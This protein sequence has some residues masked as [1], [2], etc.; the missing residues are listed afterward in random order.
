[1]GGHGQLEIHTSNRQEVLLRHLAARLRDD[2]LLP[3]QN[4]TILVPGRAMARWL[5]L[6]LARE[7]GISASLDLPFPGTFLARLSGAGPG[8]PFAREVLAL[9]I[10]RLLGD[11]AGD[12]QM[13]VPLRYCSDDADQRKRWQLSLRIASC[14]DAYQLYRDELLLGFARGDAEAASHPHAGWQAHLWRLLL[15]EC[16]ALPARTSGEPVRKRSAAPTL[17]FAEPLEPRAAKIHPHRL[18]RARELLKDPAHARAVLP[19]RLHLFGIATLPPAV[20]ALLHQIAAHVEVRLYLLLPTAEYFGELARPRGAAAV[21]PGHELLARLSRQAREFFDVLLDADPHGQ[22]MAPLEFPDPAPDPA[23]TSALAALQSDLLHLRSRGGSGAAPLVLRPADA[24]LRIHG[25]HSPLREMEVLRDQILDALE[26]E[27]GLRPHDVM[28]L[29]PDVRAYAPYVQAVFGPLGR[30][31][32]FTIADR[33]PETRAPMLAVLLRM[34]D[35]ATSGVSTPDVLHLLTEPALLRRFRLG[36]ADLPALRDL[37]ER[38]RIRLW[39]QATAGTAADEGTGP[40]QPHTYVLARQRLLFGTATGAEDRLV[41]GLLPEA[42]ATDAR[43]ETLGRLCDLCEMLQERLRA[44]GRPHTVADWARQLELTLEL[45]FEPEE[46]DELEAAEQVR[47]CARQLRALHELA[48][49]REEL[50]PAVLGEWLHEHLQASGD[51]SGLFSGGVTFAALKPM[52]ALPAEMLCIA[53]LNAEDFPRR[54]RPVPF[55]LIDA[56]PRPGDR[57]IR[58]DDRHLFLE[59]LLS[60]RRR[61]CLSWVSRSQKDDSDCAPSA[62]LSELIEH[63][64]RSCIGPGGEPAQELLLVQHPLQAF[65]SRYRDGSDE[66]LFTYELHAEAACGPAVATEFVAE[67]LPA[68]PRERTEVALEQLVSFWRN[69]ARAFCRRTLDLSLSKLDERDDECEPFAMHTLV[70]YGLQQDGVQARLCPAEGKDAE[71]MAAQRGQLPTQGLGPVAFARLD[72][73]VSVFAARLGEA[74]GPGREFTF[75]C[76]GFVLRGAVPVKQGGQA[77]QWR[78][79]SVKPKDRLMAW[80]HHLLVHAA[81]GGVTRTVIYGT[82]GSCTLEPITSVANAG[83][84]LATLLAGMQ[85]GL[86]SPLPF[87]ERASW[88]W[89][90]KLSEG[91]DPI[92]AQREARRAYLP[93]QRNDGG[94]R[95]PGDVEDPHTALCWRDQDPLLLPGFAA[96]AQRVFEPMLAHFGDREP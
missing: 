28:V 39:P 86:C 83:E 89:Q 22:G 53:G 52:R 5:R 12:R 78:M 57:S 43:A 42:S 46:R 29:V 65:S 45:L 54:G 68:E 85:E 73:E 20:M 66:R 26:H 95:V 72:L 25:C 9:R 16:G 87:F 31:L 91:K 33:S 17:P 88:E 77:I 81:D 41:H 75:A 63:L 1:V 69:P 84:W 6:Q 59:A 47:E 21:E 94:P 37:L 3:L 14:F 24:S 96:W 82:E 55:D 40:A 11:G 8:D 35:L 30:K 70:K 2:P 76:P 18:Q 7:L 62:V 32:P 38:T 48:S 49:V 50:S 64:D 80:I 90:H 61:L 92:V 60:A 79:T 71:A 4:E 44:L 10:F 93:N 67:P 34:C 19:P 15:A 74:S 23:R 51:A 36:P 56:A 27:P 58:G 13:A